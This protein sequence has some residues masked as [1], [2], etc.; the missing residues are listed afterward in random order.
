[1]TWLPKIV[2]L[3]KQRVHVP[4]AHRAEGKHLLSQLEN[5]V[6][7]K[8]RDQVEARPFLSAHLPEETTQQLEND[9]AAKTGK[10]KWRAAVGAVPGPYG[11]FL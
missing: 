9:V 5:D 4:G 10:T 7:A 11:Y 3:Q 6:A 1:M 2:D 8:N